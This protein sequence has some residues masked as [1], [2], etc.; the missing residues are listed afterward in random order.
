[1][2]KSSQFLSPHCKNGMQQNPSFYQAFITMKWGLWYL[3]SQK[4]PYAVSNSLCA[5]T[6]LLRAQ[7]TSNYNMPTPLSPPALIA[8]SKCGP[9]ALAMPTSPKGINSIDFYSGADKTVSQGV[10]YLSRAVCKPWGRTNN[11]SFTIFHPNLLIL[12]KNLPSA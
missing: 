4:F 5:K 3:K 10:D 9:S 12:E 8:P 7:M 2:T 6:G 1:M 11:I